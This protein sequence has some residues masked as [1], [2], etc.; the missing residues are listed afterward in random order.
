MYVYTHTY[1]RGVQGGLRPPPPV[2]TPPV[3]KV[4]LALQLTAYIHYDSIL[5][6][7]SLT[8]A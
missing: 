3:G 2:T 4:D 6:N 7:A 5:R 1:M 8:G